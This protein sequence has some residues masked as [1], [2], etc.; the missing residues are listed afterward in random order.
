MC[1]RPHQVV[2]MPARTATRVIETS[3]RHSRVSRAGSAW[4]PE[5]VRGLPV[6]DVLDLDGHPGPGRM[7]HVAATDVEPDMED[8][9]RVVRVIG[10]EDQ[11]SRLELADRDRSGR[12]ILR[13]RVVRQ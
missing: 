4:P 1:G 10:P 5:E 11:I 3:W 8:R 2:W 7:N 13:D 12:G 9:A 6:P